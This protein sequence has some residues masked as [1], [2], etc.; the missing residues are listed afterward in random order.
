[1]R[2]VEE[3][4]ATVASRVGTTPVMFTLH[5]VVRDVGAPLDDAPRRVGISLV[6]VNRAEQRIVRAMT[7]P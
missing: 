5:G 4:A 6:I 2:A 3:S 7:A 1:M